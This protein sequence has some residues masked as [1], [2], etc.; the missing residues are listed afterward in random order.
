MNNTSNPLDRLVV[1]DPQLAATI[2]AA[3]RDNPA[4][5]PDTLV[6]AVVEDILWTTGQEVSFG[7]AVA[8]GYAALCA[9][10]DEKCLERFHRE[11]GSAGEKGP[12][13]GRIMALNLLEVLKTGDLILADKFSDTVNGMLQKGTYTLKGPLAELVRLLHNDDLRSA[14]D[15]LELLKIAFSAHI[16]YNQSL[17]LTY[18][19]PRAVR[20]LPP[21]KRCWQIAC[22]CRVVDLDIRLVDSFLDGLA[23]GLQTL[24]EKG[25]RQ[26][27]AAGLQ[28]HEQGLSNAQTFFALESEQ[29][30]NLFDGLQVAVSF[31][32]A[33][34]QLNRYLCAR[35][36]YPVSLRPISTLSE[37]V[38]AELASD[39]LVA[40]DGKS[41][42][43]ADEIDCFQTKAANRTLYK[44]LVRFEAGLLEFH[45]FDF[46]LD[47]WLD[48]YWDEIPDSFI[49]KK[50]PAAISDLQQFFDLFSRPDLIAHLFTIFEHG[51][52]RVVLQHCY[53]GLVRQYLPLLQNAFTVAKKIPATVGL[54]ERLYAAVGLGMADQGY[55]VSGTG[56][57]CF[58]RLEKLFLDAVGPDT[59]VEYS[60]WLSF[61]AYMLL[62][63]RNWILEPEDLS[64]RPPF[65][66]GISATLYDAV[67]RSGEQAVSSIR[68][69]FNNAGFSVY[70]S[71]IRK[72]LRQNSHGL[73]TEDLRGMIRESMQKTSMP[74]AGDIDRLPL[75]DF[76][77]DRL[78]DLVTGKPAAEDISLVNAAWYREWDF[79]LADYLN[80]HTRVIDRSVTGVE[81][82]FYRD[83]LEK[84]WGLV[85]R[86][87]YSFELLKPEGLKIFRQW[88][89]GDE[90]D[91]RALVDFAVDRKTG[92]TPSDRLYIKRL[93]AE[94]SV[95]VLLLVDLSRSTSNTITGSTLSV[96]D[97]EKEAI[98]LLAEALEVVGDDF[99]IAGFSGN[100]RL[101]VDYFHI[102]D[103]DEPFDT[104]TRRRINAMV[105]Q[106]N[107][108]MGAAIRHAADQFKPVA[109]KVRLLILLG[110]G[111]PNDVD[112]KKEYAVADTRKAVSELAARQIHV[113]AITVNMNLNGISVLD[114]LYGDI[115]HSLISNVIELPDKLLRI[116]GALTR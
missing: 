12:T 44:C 26:F 61:Q 73:S 5:V 17:H 24:N 82:S 19:L 64:L 79:R 31:T 39:V 15:Y 91:Y 110:D 103:F 23:R 33:A 112:Y 58:R 106:R 27:A 32:Q 7:Q 37:A 78:S 76:N 28:I 109:S 8:D 105:P 18:V 54:L 53:P 4:D 30:R 92:R 71:V 102:K 77:M 66:R 95:S 63:K 51:R 89:E 108:R 11:I 57:E 97:V 50:T 70:R 35:I 90:F 42:F 36:G 114:D 13:L 16:S 100:G 74:G 52:I 2:D 84:Y 60:A 3:L 67:N 21:K 56:D 81:D 116:Y 41:I 6:T 69:Q 85:K 94:R 38:R 10:A 25:L 20:D 96:L 80:D 65:G 93:K 86:V 111:F 83:T 40:S 14:A 43:L 101:G 48:R 62:E 34:P 98:V 55:R 46:D 29:G 68:Q 107:T 113:H 59:P 75:D 99:A 47:I 9:V 72:H 88:V 1:F 45:T 49:T 22:L 115:H 87:R 104:R